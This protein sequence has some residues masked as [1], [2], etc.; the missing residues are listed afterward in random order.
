M[1]IFI[2]ILFLLICIAPAAAQKECDVRNAPA[3]LNLNLGISTAQAR[4]ANNRKL[5]VKNENDGEYTFFENYIDKSPKGIL[6]G[7]K[8]V[9]LRFYKGKLF[10]IELFYKDKYKWQNLSQLIGDY[11]AQNNFPNDFWTID[12][13]YAKADCAGFALKADYIL[14]PHIQLTDEEIFRQVEASRK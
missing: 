9:Y 11:S 8:A 12:Y 14:N 13:G 5:K 7:L 4:N 6:E 10:Q 3:L 2:L 1:K